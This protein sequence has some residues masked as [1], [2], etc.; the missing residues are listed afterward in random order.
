MGR[1]PLNNAAQQHYNAI[2]NKFILGESIPVAAE[3]ESGDKSLLELMADVVRAM[4]TPVTPEMIEAGRRNA[5]GPGPDTFDFGAIYCAMAAL[6]PVELVSEGERQA[7]RERDEMLTAL[8]NIRERNT[9]LEAEVP[10]RVQLEIAGLR[11]ERD[12]ALAMHDTA[13]TRNRLLEATVEGQHRTMLAAQEREIALRTELMAAH[14]KMAA[15]IA[16]VADAPSPDWTRVPE[17]D[18]R[19]MGPEGI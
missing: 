10:G 18:R 5:Y 12:E 8:N 15:V 3:T 16:N 7:V 9:T 4:G 1:E 17:P 14:D 13:A 19:R 11:V 2:R 6:A